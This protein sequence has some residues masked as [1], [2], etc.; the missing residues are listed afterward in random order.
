[1]IEQQKY[2]QFEEVILSTIFFE[3]TKKKFTKRFLSAEGR[4]RAGKTNNNSV[5]C[6]ARRERIEKKLI[7]TQ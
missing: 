5:E 7:T 6:A 4:N 2:L 3:S 1:M